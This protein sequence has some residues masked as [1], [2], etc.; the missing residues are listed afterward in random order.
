VRGIEGDQSE[1]RNGYYF[2]PWVRGIEGD[3]SE[4][5]NGYYFVPWVRGIEGDQSEGVGT[6][7]L[8]SL[9]AWLDIGFTFKN[10]LDI[11]FTFKN[12]IGTRFMAIWQRYVISF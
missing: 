12:D 4:G 2:V 1:G 6:L 3:Q 8:W 10:I 9:G 11:G 7:L 5:R